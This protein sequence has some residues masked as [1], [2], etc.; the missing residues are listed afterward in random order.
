M[1]ARRGGGGQ[2]GGRAGGRAP[3]LLLLLLLAA[4]PRL[5]GRGAWEAWRRACRCDQTLVPACAGDP[6]PPPQVW[7]K[8]SAELQFLYGNHVLK[9]GLGRITEGTP[10]YTGARSSGRRSRWLVGGESGAAGSERRPG[11][12][13]D[14]E[15]KGAKGARH[16]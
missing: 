14:A 12:R 13:A 8:P 11:A 15:R 3:P 16:A 5:C 9:S 1:L 7:V 2:A 6:P 10:A 4:E